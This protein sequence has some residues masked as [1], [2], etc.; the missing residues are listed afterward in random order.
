MSSRWRR[1]SKRR[2]KEIGLTVNFSPV[3]CFMGKKDVFLSNAENKQRII[4]LIAK[5]MTDNGITVIHARDDADVDIVMTCLDSAK[6][7]STCLIGEDT[8][9]LILLLY[10]MDN[11]KFNI[12]FRSDVK[13]S[14]TNKQNI[15][16]DIRS[17]QRSLDKDVLQSLLCLHAFTGSDTTSRVYSVG[18]PAIFKKLLDDEPLR[19]LFQSFSCNGRNQKEVE[20]LGNSIMTSFFGG[21]IN[22]TLTCCRHRMFVEKVSSAKS[23]V[24][25]ERLPPTQSANKYHSLRSYYQIRV[26]QGTAE[27][28]KVTDWGWTTRDG[29]LAP[30]SM[31][32]APAPESLLK[33]MRCNC[34]TGCSNNRCG[35]RKN[36]FPCNQ[37]C[38]ICQ[39][40][41]CENVL[42]INSQDSDED[43]SDSDCNE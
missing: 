20:E 36:G 28:L 23:F 12:Y 29:Q 9:L 43:V 42:S 2:T 13:R 18:K 35:C 14:N 11:D 26:W 15:I 39:E 7:H 8:D 30:V 37:A 17:L 32:L 5:T 27:N 19:Q 24:K 41:Q 21:K 6:S 34:T 3:M 33:T 16:Y 25:P 22:E 40:T 1:I 4:N 38:G 10:H 31:D